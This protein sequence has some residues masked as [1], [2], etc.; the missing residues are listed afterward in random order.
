MVNSINL[1]TVMHEENMP[2]RK[3][4]ET[5]PIVLKLRPSP[6]WSRKSI[7][8]Y[9]DQSVAWDEENVAETRYAKYRSV[10]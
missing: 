4:P 5:P 10:F 6:G 8:S 7:E 3:A 1:V 9:I 2:A